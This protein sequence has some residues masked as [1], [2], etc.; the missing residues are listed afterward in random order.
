MVRSV[1][2]PGVEAG[3]SEHHDVRSLSRSRAWW[4]EAWDSGRP[5]G[6]E[7]T[8]THVLSHGHPRHTI[9]RGLPECTSPGVLIR[10]DL[11]PTLRITWRCGG[12]PGRPM[13]RPEADLDQHVKQDVDSPFPFG[14]RGPMRD[15]VPSAH[16]L[17]R[18][19]KFGTCSREVG[20][21]LIGHAVLNDD[22]G[23]TSC[24][25][26]S[27]LD[28]VGTAPRRSADLRRLGGQRRRGGTLG[29]LDFAARRS[30]CSV[31]STSSSLPLSFR[32]KNEARCDRL[33]RARHRVQ[34]GGARGGCG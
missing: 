4:S 33:I 16:Q 18:V 10:R 13:C 2:E 29:P 9:G 21:E 8:A 5:R 19:G 12:G 17:P 22:H 20:R 23:S 34:G 7:Q 28:V 27:G 1:L 30:N 32:R 15:R 24:A 3:Q 25:G 31:P 11:E 14:H 6:W 26:L